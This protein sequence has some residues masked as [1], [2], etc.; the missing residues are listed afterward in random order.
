MTASPTDVA[1]S[2]E[3]SDRRR[4]GWPDPMA[5]ALW[6][7]TALVAATALPAANWT[8]DLNLVQMTAS[9]GLG[10]GLL[11]VGSR[12][13]GG[14]AAALAAGYG[15]TVIV[16]QMAATLDPGMA[17][18]ERVFDLANRIWIFLETV[19]R[20][21]RSYNSLMF[22]LAMALVY[23]FAAVFGSWRL[24]RRGGTWAGL[25]APGVSVFLNVYYYR[26]G[27]RL[28]I[29]LPV[30]L[31]L[32]LALLARLEFLRRWR[33]WELNR[34]QVPTDI[35]GRITAAGAIAGFV[36]VGAAWLLPEIPDTDISASGG[37]AG[38]SRIGDLFSDAFAGLR[39]PVNLYG[40]AF[41]DSLS[42]GPGQD[43]GSRAV[44]QAT[45]RGEIPA[46]SRPYWRARVFDTYQDGQWSSQAGEE[47]PY[48]PG[49]FGEG[50]PA[51]QGRVEVE[52]L[53]SPFVP[54][55][56]LLYLPSQVVWFNRSAEVRQT[57][58]DG[59]MVEILE[60]ISGEIL[61]PGDT[62]RVRSHLAAPLAGDLRLAGT[63]YP[64]WVRESYLQL[65]ANLPVS[66]SETAAV[67]TQGALT[68]Y[69]RAAAIT[70]WLRE[71]ILYQRV[72]E[73]PPPGRDPVEW[74]LLDSRNRVL[75]LLHQRH[76]V[77]APGLGSPGAG[78]G[79]L[80]RRGFRAAGEPLLRL[81]SGEPFLARGLLPRLRLGGV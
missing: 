36:L 64:D 74:F 41:A 12:F 65:P 3:K 66:I 45:V 72:T 69:D 18:R 59:E 2:G 21:E 32:A 47:T 50:P 35:A 28:Q 40:E 80:C 62:Y 70:T 26:F 10:L 20:G 53:I 60:A 52:F 44:F 23:W 24:F 7:A 43:P 42:L 22:V 19:I 49:D 73:A 15:A 4:G 1:G 51:R 27:D 79:R 58:Q 81:G 67:V 55:M 8:D 68:P 11:L 57:V 14:G 34:A 9:L 30:F 29:Y 75:R 56:R 33:G 54:A 16:F 77:D 78:G 63:T 38:G 39:A 48:R 46:E 25:F 31:L 5:F 37:G 76:G 6:S 71:N 61:V 13:G 17:W